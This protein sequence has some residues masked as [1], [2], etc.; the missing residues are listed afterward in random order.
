M[1]LIPDLEF[2]GLVYQ[3]TD[4]DGLA[5][6]LATGP[7]T[8][9][10]G[11]DPTAESMTVGNLVPILLLRR[12]QLAGHKAIALAGGGTGLIGDPSGKSEERQLN[13]DDTV[14]AW[15]EKVKGD[16]Y[17]IMH[18]EKFQVPQTIDAESVADFLRDRTGMTVTIERSM[19]MA[20]IWLAIFFGVVLAAIPY[21]MN[22][23]DSFWLPLMRSKKNPK[24]S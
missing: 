14:A 11:F 17:N 18:R 4:L 1:N 22:S 19:I 21:I 8:V 6:R 10:T 20:Y 13:T 3:A 24:S 15:T 23:L 12:Y 5:E 2:R 9:Y 16:S 7:I